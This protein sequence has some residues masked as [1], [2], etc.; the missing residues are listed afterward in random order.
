MNI[1]AITLDT[2]ATISQDLKVHGQSGDAW[3]RLIFGIHPRL[4]AVTARFDASSQLI[5]SSTYRIETIY[6]ESNHAPAVET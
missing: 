1:T 3:V 4:G 2:W 6:P 5:L